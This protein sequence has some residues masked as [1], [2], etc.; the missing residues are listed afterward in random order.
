MMFLSAHKGNK[1]RRGAYVATLAVL[2]MCVL[3]TPV[4]AAAHTHKHTTHASAR[5][6]QTQTIF[7]GG[8]S[9]RFSPTQ[10]LRAGRRGLLTRVDLPLCTFFRGS[11]VQLD[12]TGRT[13]RHVARA[14]TTMTFQNSFSDCV[15]FSFTFRHPL[16]VGVG[17]PLELRVSA[18]RG[19]APLWASNAHENVD[20]YRHGSGSWRGIKINDFAFRTYVQS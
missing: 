9:V 16:F 8:L 7:A 5:L 10:T 2:G 11:V 3:A 19:A 18:R 14:S 6:D 4:A 12:I 20:P 1:M 17:E 13:G 15:W